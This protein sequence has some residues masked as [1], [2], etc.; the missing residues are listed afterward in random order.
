MWQSVGVSVVLVA[1]V[2]GVS[3]VIDHSKVAEQQRLSTPQAEVALITI[4]DLYAEKEVV[5]TS[6]ETVLDLLQILDAQDQQVRLAT[7]EYSGLGTLVESIGGKANGMNDEYWQYT[8][9]GVMPQI[10]ADVFTLSP[11]DSVE[12]YFGSSEL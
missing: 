2:L 6:G 7:K 3:T 11:G 9:N 12:W 1:L 10:G 8:V 5:I 4:E